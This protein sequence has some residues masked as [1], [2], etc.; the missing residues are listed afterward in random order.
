MARVVNLGITIPKVLMNAIEDS[1]GDISRSKYVTRILERSLSI[2]LVDNQNNVV[3][4]N[5]LPPNPSTTTT[6][7][8]SIPLREVNLNGGN[9]HNNG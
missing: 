8:D 5:G 2:M 3:E 1:R 6:N 7:T 9:H 4:G